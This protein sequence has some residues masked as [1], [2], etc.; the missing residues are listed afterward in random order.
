MCIR[1]RSGWGLLYEYEPG[2]EERNNRRKN[3]LLYTSR[4]EI[5]SVNG[6]EIRIQRGVKV[7]IKRKFAEVLDHSVESDEGAQDYIDYKAKG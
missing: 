7:K 5:V 1:D 4:H 6:E 3:C 2:Y